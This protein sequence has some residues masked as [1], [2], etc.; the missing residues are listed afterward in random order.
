MESE[1]NI[2]SHI[3]VIKNKINN[4]IYIGQA[5]SHRLN[6]GKYRYFGYLG[7]FKDHISEA[8][9]N[10]KEN[11]CTYLNNAIRKYDTENFFVELIEVCEKDK[12]DEREIYHINKH[13]S[14]Y[15]NGYNLTIGGK[16]FFIN[17]LKNIDEELE[18]PKLNEKQNHRG[19]DYGY[20]HKEETIN[21]MKAFYIQKQNYI[22]FIE[23][24]KNCMK[25]SISNYF[26]NNKIE[27]LSKYILE[28]PLEQYIKQVCLKNTKNPY[29]YLIKIND[30]KFKLINDDSLE[31]KYNRLLNILKI[32]YQKSKN[33]NDIPKGK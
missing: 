25:E 4:K 15:P 26:D 22:E 5:I 19:R 17:N 29:N 24:K 21:K 11:Q 32:S 18:K 7:R 23:N 13:N 14:L 3:Y 6:K 28:L 33:C 9:C 12:S 1:D 16:N 27:K 8:I 2:K 20:I 10:T 31:N 30:K